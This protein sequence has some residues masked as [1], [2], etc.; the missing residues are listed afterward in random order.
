M[1]VDELFLVDFLGRDIEFGCD[2]DAA[3]LKCIADVVLHGLGIGVR[4]DKH[5]CRIFQAA[6]LHIL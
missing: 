1:F 2:R 5:Q 3:F 6:I 4:F